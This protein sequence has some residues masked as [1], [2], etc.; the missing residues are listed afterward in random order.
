MN[1]YMSIAGGGQSAIREWE[2]LTTAILAQ[3]EQSYDAI[4]R[5]L[6]LWERNELGAQLADV[7]PDEPIGD[8][9][10]TG[11][12]VAERAAVFQSLLTWLNTPVPVGE[13]ENTVTPL[14]LISR[15]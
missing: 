1:P 3:L 13:G 15:R 7:A 14:D 6:R 2:Q 12:Q 8:G 5:P 10:L 4:A 11:M 9:V